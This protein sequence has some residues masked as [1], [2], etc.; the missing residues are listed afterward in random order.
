MTSRELHCE[1]PAG[2]GLPSEARQTVIWG[3]GDCAAA[4]DALR[5]MHAEGGAVIVRGLLADAEAD[6]VNIPSARLLIVCRGPTSAILAAME[7]GS[8]PSDA[9]EDWTARMKELLRVVRSRRR[10]VAV[11]DADQTLRDPAALAHR[12]NL[13]TSMHPKLQPDSGEDHPDPVRAVIAA[14]ALRMDA[15]AFA[16]AGELAASTL[17]P[18]S[19]PDSHSGDRAYLAYK[20]FK[21]EDALLRQQLRIV[22]ERMESTYIE[23][24]NKN[25]IIQKHEQEITRHKKTEEELRKRVEKKAKSIIKLNAELGRARDTVQRLNSRPNIIAWPLRLIRGPVGSKAVTSPKRR[26]KQGASEKPKEKGV[27]G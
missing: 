14:V 6:L 25:S 2:L 1:G 22:Q 4:L 12:L 7:A 23:V 19:Y 5:E 9:L 15:A 11:V 13:S 20:T 3:D 16:L 27:D 18:P 24:R 26:K 10:Q 8:L 17:N 21:E